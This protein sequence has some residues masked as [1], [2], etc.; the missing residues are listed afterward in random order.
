MNQRRALLDRL[1]AFVLMGL[2]RTAWAWGFAGVRCSAFG[3]GLRAG[4]WA[5]GGN[6]RLHS[7]PLDETSARREVSHDR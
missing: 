3:I 2:S 5:G 7:L 4:H 1:A 6:S